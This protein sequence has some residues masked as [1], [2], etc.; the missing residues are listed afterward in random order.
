VRE[1]LWERLVER[2]AHARR[3]GALRSIE[4][5]SHILE[6]GGIRFLVRQAVAPDPKPRAQSAAA[7]GQRSN[8]F[9][10]YEEALFVGDIS[11]THLCLLNKFTVVDHHL[12]IVTREFE[13]QT[14]PLTLGD[15]DALWRCMEALDGLAFYNSGREAGASQAHKHIQMIPGSGE[16]ETGRSSLDE[17]FAEAARRGVGSTVARLP[18]V[19]ALAPTRE[20]A[21]AEP[22]QA[23]IG[24]LELYRSLLRQVGNAGGPAAYN[25]L[26]TRRWMLVVPR[27]R[28]SH[29]SIEV[30]ALGYSGALFAR[31]PAQLATLREIGPLRVLSDVGVEL[32]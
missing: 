3:C 8:P 25:L 31:S 24:S 9:L 18:F 6:D 16:A 20:L 26:V 4:T 7:S 5:E 23:A 32:R 28:E 12:L 17:L 14:S 21:R 1:G 13:Q 29:A 27:R 19:H 22:R 2:S 10:P 30:N 15:F 11:P